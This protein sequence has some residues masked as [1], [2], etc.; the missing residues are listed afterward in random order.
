MTSVI[1]QLLAEEA[2]VDVTLA[3]DGA[4]IKAHRVSCMDF[5]LIHSRLSEL[6]LFD[7]SGCPLRLFP[8]FST[9]TPRQSLQASS[10]DPT[11]WS[12]SCRSQ[13]DR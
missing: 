7:L 4:R 6:R 12:R 10:V 5:H 1:N 2:F 3:C 9:G 8:L 13:G 11:R